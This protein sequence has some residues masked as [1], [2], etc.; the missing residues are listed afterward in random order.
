MSEW[1]SERMQQSIA[2]RRANVTDTKHTH[3]V[4]EQ[5]LETESAK[6][7]WKEMRMPYAKLDRRRAKQRRFGGEG[8]IF[9]AAH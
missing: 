5:Q 6:E 8:E 4:I 1:A 3:T 2:L 7:K 9:G